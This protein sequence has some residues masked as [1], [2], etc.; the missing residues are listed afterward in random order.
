MGDYRVTSVL[1]D[2]RRGRIPRDHLTM[3]H[4]I[5]HQYGR[6]VDGSFYNGAGAYRLSPNVGPNPMRGAPFA[7][8]WDQVYG[9]WDP[10]HLIYPLIDHE[11]PKG[12]L[13]DQRKQGTNVSY[14]ADHTFVGHT[15]PNIALCAGSCGV[16]AGLGAYPEKVV[17]YLRPIIDRASEQLW[18]S[19]PGAQAWRIRPPA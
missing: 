11:A 13:R 4:V 9:F 8:S 10:P 12:Q 3:V 14:P 7:T 6:M 18:G 5:K 15:Y 2:Y 17:A 16:M 19:S 1:M